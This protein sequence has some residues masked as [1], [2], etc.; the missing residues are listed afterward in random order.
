MFLLS[1]AVDSGRSLDCASELSTA[2]AASFTASPLTSLH[3][4][5]HSLRMFLLSIVGSLVKMKDK[6]HSV[7]L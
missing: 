5:P 3:L 1:A 4:A 2:S 6:M 7:K